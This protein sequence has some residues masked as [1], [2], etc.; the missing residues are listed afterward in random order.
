MGGDMEN[1]RSVHRLKRL[2]G[3]VIL[4]FEISVREEIF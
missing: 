2:F 3:G 4:H 1:L